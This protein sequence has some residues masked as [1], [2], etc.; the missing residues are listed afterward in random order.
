MATKPSAFKSG[1]RL[2][3][4]DKIIYYCTFVDELKLDKVREEEEKE[5]KPKLSEN[6][7]TCINIFVLFRDAFCVPCKDKPKQK[8]MERQAQENLTFPPN[9]QFWFEVVKLI[10]KAMLIILGC[11][12]DAWPGCC[13]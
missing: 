13:W 8:D 10:T 11:G 7:Q 6:Y 1:C 4:F 2:A 12:C 9:Y 5:K 3:G